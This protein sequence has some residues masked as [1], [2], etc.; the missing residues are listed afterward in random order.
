M[1]Q[2]DGGAAPANASVR[3]LVDLQGVTKAYGAVRALGGVDFAIAAGECVGLA[4][5][6]GAGKSTLMQVL[7]GNV[8]PDTGTLSV[9]G[10]DETGRYSVER[11]GRLGV[12]CVFQ[13]LSLCPNLTVAENARVRHAFLRG[14]GWRARAATLITGQLDAIFPGHGIRPGD[15]V[16]D[17]ALGQRQMVEIAT[18]FAAGETPLSLVILDE[19]T[20]SLDAQVAGQLLAHVRRFVAEGGSVVLISHI[21]GEI[22]DTCDRITVMS[23]GRVVADRPASEFTR[24][25]LVEAM[26]HVAHTDDTG[27]EPETAAERSGTPVVA[28][29]APPRQGNGRRVEARRGE[30]IGLGGL[31]G[32]GQTALLVLLQNASRGR[33]R[34]AELHGRTAFVAGDRQ[35]DGVFPL[36]SIGGNVTVRSLSALS[37]FGLIDARAERAM[38][39]AW[40]ARIAIRTPDMGNGILT[41]SGGNQQKALFARALASDA[42]IVLMDDPMRGVDIGTKQEVYALIRA[43]AAKGR[44]F[45]WYTTEFDELRAC[46]H[47]YVFRS[48]RI[49]AD[50]ARS[51]LSEARVLQSSFEE[52]AA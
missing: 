35:S 45:L 50:M 28:A 47:V 52:S 38:E 36:W 21:L 9:A 34:F 42:E 3:P 31:A 40:K 14:F 18:V 23:D 6:N 22:L 46:D 44:T 24:H 2:S 39:D 26:G 11:A 4:G 41:L 7:A 30:I 1:M 19:P 12:R 27:S 10:S 20:S 13:E 51:E 25:S 16:S 33:S 17:L 48:G 49:V 5:H 29:A 15:L 43:E 8:R 32:H 37:R